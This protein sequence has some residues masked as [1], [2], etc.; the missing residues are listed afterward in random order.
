MGFWSY[1]HA[2]DKAERGRILDLSGRLADQFQLLTGDSIDIFIDRSSLE[3]GDAWRSTISEAI[4]SAAFFIPVITPTY[5]RRTECRRE[6]QE[7]IGHARSLGL[8]E[9]VLPII[10]VDVEAFDDSNSDT[11]VAQVAAIQGIDWRELRV[12]DPDSAPYVQAI[13]RAAQHLVAIRGSIEHR[14]G[15]STPDA[16][17]SLP[18]LGFIELVARIRELLPAWQQCIDDDAV[19]QAQ[20]DATVE[21][22]RK[23][24][25]SKNKFAVEQS[26]GRELLPLVERSLGSS[27]LYTQLTMEL[28]PIVLDAL[29]IIE[30]HP[31]EGWLLDE[32]QEAFDEFSLNM[33]RHQA[34]RDLHRAGEISRVSDWAGER[35]HRSALMKELASRS[36]MA[37]GRTDDANMLVSNWIDRSQALREAA[38][39]DS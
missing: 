6:L 25:T 28:D 21:T 16:S 2:D 33:D 13:D 12:L 38:T 19:V 31:D 5:F 7:F 23:R 14:R 15:R 35:A 9:L 26:I 8:Q 30:D 22:R 39:L 17:R 24:Q 27:D 10:Y 34:L 20:I 29:R 32:L 36:S 3:W 1:A 18:G 11:L 4:A 37:L